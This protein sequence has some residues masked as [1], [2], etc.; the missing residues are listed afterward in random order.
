MDRGQILVSGANGFIGRRTIKHLLEKSGAV[1][2]VMPG[3]T[4]GDV[5]ERD[6]RI[7]VLA[8][9]E[10]NEETFWEDSLTGVDVVLHLAARAHVLNEPK[11]D[12]L[13]A[14][15]KVNVEGS[16]HLGRQAAQRGIKR[17]V[18]ISSIGVNGNEN[19]KP[20]KIDDPPHPQEPYAISKLEAEQGL[21]QISEETGMELVI[22][23]PPLVY[24]PGAPG[25]FGRL[26]RLVKTGIPLPFGLVRNRRSLVALDNLVDL[27]ITC[28]EHPAA[29]GQTFLVSDGEDLSTP[30]LIRKLASAM[31]R[32][33]R[34]LPVPPAFLRLGGRMLGKGPEVAR[35]LNSLQVDI[36]HTCKT[37]DWRPSISVDEG[38]K[39]TAEWY[40]HGSQ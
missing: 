38:L 22:I 37:L 27:I 8:P 5:L 17:F 26:A 40:M 12:S 29:A 10:I 3:R 11:G 32:P 6:R 23:R 4:Q 20:F 9:R 24:G 21:R 28:V 25:N 35:L 16:L 15:R 13:A 39:E 36:R 14:F 1:I 31:G 30:E 18:F 34:L 19:S 2:K 33:A 7:D